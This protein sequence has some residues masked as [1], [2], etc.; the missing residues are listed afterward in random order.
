[1]IDKQFP[2]RMITW[3]QDFL[4]KRRARVRIKDMTSQFREFTEGFP[5]GTILG[6][7]FWD[8]IVDDI[9]PTLKNCI[10]PQYKPE[11]LLYAD[12]ITIVLQAKPENRQ[13]LI[14]AT[15]KCVQELA[16]WEKVATC[17]REPR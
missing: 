15:Q 9:I 3:F 5:Q 13:Q 16:I 14:Q 11:C 1:M 7:R 2:P 17:Y 8:L 10:P 12:D 6:P 4:T